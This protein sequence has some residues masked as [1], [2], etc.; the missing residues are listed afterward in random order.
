LIDECERMGVST[1]GTPRILRHRI[2]RL[3]DRG[4]LCLRCTQM[5]KS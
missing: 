2:K 1:L 4:I 3:K 5:S